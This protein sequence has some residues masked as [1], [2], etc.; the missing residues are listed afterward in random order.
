M[1]VN[2][3][4]ASRLPQPERP[5]RRSAC[6]VIG[7][8]VREFASCA[9]EAVFCGF[10]SNGLSWAGLRAGGIPGEVLIGL[11]NP[12]R[13]TRAFIRGASAALGTAAFSKGIGASCALADVTGDLLREGFNKGVKGKL[14]DDYLFT[15]YSPVT[16]ALLTIAYTIAAGKGAW[17]DIEAVQVGDPRD[18]GLLSIFADVAYSRRSAIAAGVAVG[19]GFA[20]SRWNGAPQAAPPSHRYDD[21]VN[22]AGARSNGAKA[23]TMRWDV[24]VASFLAGV[25][26]KGESGL[27][28]DDY[29]LGSKIVGSCLSAYAIYGICHDWYSRSRVFA[30]GAKPLELAPAKKKMLQEW[31]M[32]KTLAFLEAELRDRSNELEHFPVPLIDALAETVNFFWAHMTI[33]SMINTGK[34]LKPSAE[35]YEQML[36]PT[37]TQQWVSFTAELVLQGAVMLLQMSVSDGK[38]PGHGKRKGDVAATMVTALG[39]AVECLARYTEI[40]GQVGARGAIQ[41]L[42]GGAAMQAF[43][44]GARAAGW[45]YRRCQGG[46][47]SAAA[48]RKTPIDADAEQAR[49]PAPPPTWR[50]PFH[51]YWE[52]MT[53]PFVTIWEQ[54]SFTCSRRGGLNVEDLAAVVPPG[55]A[56]GEAV[57]AMERVVSKL[58]RGNVPPEDVV[59]DAALAHALAQRAAQDAE[60]ASAPDELRESKGSHTVIHGD[61]EVPDLEPGLAHPV[62]ADGAGVQL[63]AAAFTPQRFVEPPARRNSFSVE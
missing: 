33:V 24:M 31:N 14:G 18:S 21:F 11:F 27:M 32:P 15:V 51:K 9:W 62:H 40:T 3:P 53:M 2:N 23:G 19:V 55:E 48:D 38:D 52:E 63:P 58:E 57:V 47:D 60:I 42:W 41:G 13:D 1:M 61:P 49:E 4:N 10:V 26:T 16:H 54:L 28:V 17:D 22:L 8:G 43:P 20:W 29:P 45:L 25:L 56:L 34:S 39:A 12:G 59:F 44:Y 36:S 46:G 35:I 6:N 37:A 7:A 30:K 5:T 50:D